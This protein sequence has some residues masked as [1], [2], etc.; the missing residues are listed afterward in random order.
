[1][2]QV[3]AQTQNSIKAKAS[4]VTFQTNNA[5]GAITFG[6]GG[7]QIVLN[8][9]GGAGT[10]LKLASSWTRNAQATVS[11][12]VSAGGTLLATPTTANG[13]LGYGVITDSTGTGF[14]TTNLVPGAL[15]RYTDTT[16]ERSQVWPHF[17]LFHVCARVRHQI[18]SRSRGSVGLNPRRCATRRKQNGPL[19]C[20]SE[21]HQNQHRA[22]L[23]H[24]S[25]ATIALTSSSRRRLF[26]PNAKNAN[27]GVSYFHDGTVT[28][29]SKTRP[30]L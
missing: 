15:A 23:L 5:N 27:C 9:N 10:T 6:A 28:T 24:A 8:P 21:P 1:L 14:I 20:V 30:P 29:T 25:R 3:L 18:V 17:G 4:D 11:V 12:D 7:S 19:T 16:I 13:V 22:W 26:S 2:R